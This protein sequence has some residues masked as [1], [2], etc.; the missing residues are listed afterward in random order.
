MVRTA[1]ILVRN[2]GGSTTPAATSS[3]HLERDHVPYQVPPCR[4]IACRQMNQATGSPIAMTTI[5]GTS[6][7]AV[8]PSA[9][10][11]AAIVPSGH[12]TETAPEDQC[13][14]LHAEPSAIA[15]RGPWSEGAPGPQ[16]GFQRNEHAGVVDEPLD[17]GTP[18]GDEQI[19][20]IA[21][22][23][24][25]QLD[26][27]GTRAGSGEDRPGRLGCWVQLDPG[28]TS[29]HLP[30]AN[31][32]ARRRLAQ[33]LSK[34]RGRPLNGH[35]AGSRSEHGHESADWSGRD[36]LCAWGTQAEVESERSHDTILT[37]VRRCLFRLEDQ[38]VARLGHWGRW[39]A[40]SRTW[41]VL[42]RKRARSSCI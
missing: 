3:N 32:R 25:S 6:V 8:M 1:V 37:G 36:R 30:L 7:P 23:G 34:Q 39:L 28:L 26:T 33:E 24:T 27:N 14:A 10:A 5:A 4:R 12:P 41:P 16:L 21:A 35:L 13:E 20:P 38:A 22:T 2:A 40:P 15:E 17:G 19:D 29:T 42:R 31:H 9:S 11:A 18:I